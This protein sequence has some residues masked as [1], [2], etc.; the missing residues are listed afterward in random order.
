[1]SPIKACM[2]SVLPGPNSD[3]DREMEK[4]HCLAVQTH[5]LHRLENEM[6]DNM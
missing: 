2:A 3:D 5:L 4:E 6:T 1:M